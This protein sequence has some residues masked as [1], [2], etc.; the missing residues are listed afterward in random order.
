M[1]TN[2]RNK[3]KA[4]KEIENT[5]LYGKKSGTTPLSKLVSV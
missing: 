5:A 2:E 4:L 1:V 3:E